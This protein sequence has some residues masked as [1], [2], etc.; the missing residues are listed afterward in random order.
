ME[1]LW[2]GLL[3]VAVFSAAAELAYVGSKA[4]VGLFD[5]F[6]PEDYDD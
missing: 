3:V 2:A 4:L 1:V 6:F 5:V